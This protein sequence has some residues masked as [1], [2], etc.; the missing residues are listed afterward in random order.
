V[1]SPKSLTISSFKKIVDDRYDADKTLRREMATYVS[2]YENDYWA[3]QGPADQH[4]S[5]ITANLIFSN[6]NQIAPLMTD[7]S[8]IWGL[9]PRF[10]FLQTLGN[11]W[12]EGLKAV[13]SDL[14]MDMKVFMVY[15]DALVKET[16]FVR[17]GYDKDKEDVTVD[18]ADPQ[19]MV[20]PAGYEELK[21]CSWVCE[22]KPKPLSWVWAEFPETIDKVVPDQDLEHQEDFFNRINAGDVSIDE[23]HEKSVMVYDAWIRDPTTEK[24]MAAAHGTTHTDAS[25]KDKKFT[26]KYPNGRLLMFTGNQTL[27][28]DDPSPFHHGMPPWVAVYD[29]RRPHNVWGMGEVRQ[30]KGLV[31]ELQVQIQ[32]ISHHIRNH[33]RTNYAADASDVEFIENFKKTFTKGD[34]VY[35]VNVPAAARGRKVSDMIAPIA[36]P[37]VPSDIGAWIQLLR[38]LV[39]EVTGVTDTS[40]GIA[41]KRARQ[42]AREIDVMLETSNTR[43]R[44]RVRNLEHS[45]KNVLTVILSV[46]QQYYVEPRSF[47]TQNNDG[48]SS[49]G[50]ISNQSDFAVNLYEKELQFRK[51]QMQISEEQGDEKAL[52]AEMRL[53][54]AATEDLNAIMDHVDKEGTPEL[55][56]SFDIEIYTNSQLPIDK[57]SQASLALQL[58]RDKA[59]DRKDVLRKL[60]W[61]DGDNVAARMEAKEEAEKQAKKGGPPPGQPP[62]AQAAPGSQQFG[63]QQATDVSD[64]QASE[65]GPQQQQ[66]A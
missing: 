42:S 66:G 18:I 21:D 48:S 13:W 11:H 2:M 27:L 41:E 10:G 37:D 4:L 46:M 47:S 26:K 15:L 30:V 34:Q 31:Q 12:N 43:T 57:Q 14:D 56:A 44:Q 38:D 23:A 8:P 54:T 1:K 32:A 36:R 39:E 62:P 61:P 63:P 59:I 64:Q 7:S 16:G 25:G 6:I 17:V 53:V 22:R 58:H 5:K 45:L 52:A 33:L 51:L 20:F 55:L 40:K 65:A 3:R 29:Y 35:A 28:H 49:F 60:Q 9:R 50:E 24:A 19:F